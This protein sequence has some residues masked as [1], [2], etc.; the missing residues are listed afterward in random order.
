MKKNYICYCFGYSKE[1]IIKDVM[2][3]AGRSFILERIMN[4]KKQGGCNCELNHPDGR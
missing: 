4:E 2:E 1:D 3:N